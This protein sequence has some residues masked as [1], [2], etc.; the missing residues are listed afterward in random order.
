M[1]VALTLVTGTKCW[2]LLVFGRCFLNC[3]FLIGLHTLSNGLNYFSVAAVLQLLL[4]A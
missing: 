4:C 3:T 2:P 1:L